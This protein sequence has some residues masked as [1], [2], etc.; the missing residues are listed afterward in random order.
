MTGSPVISAAKTDHLHGVVCIDLTK[1]VGKSLD[2]VERY[3]AMEME[4]LEHRLM[5]RVLD[6][7]E[8]A[9]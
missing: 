2:E 1:Q 9:A 7:V 4:A 8:T 6:N 3:L 5:K